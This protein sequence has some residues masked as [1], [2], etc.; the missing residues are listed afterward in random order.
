MVHQPQVALLT[1]LLGCAEEPPPPPEPA[2]MQWRRAGHLSAAPATGSFPFPG[3]RALLATCTHTPCVAERWEATDGTT[4]D[5]LRDGDQVR[6][7]GTPETHQTGRWNR[8]NGALAVCIGDPWSSTPGGDLAAVRTLVAHD[9]PSSDKTA[10]WVIR[11]S[12]ENPC[13]LSGDLELSTAADR[14]WSRGLSCEGTAWA[15]GGPKRARAL[16][17][18]SAPRG[19]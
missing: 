8:L 19:E 1:L 6:W 4:R 14:V 18:V 13:R 11:F 3:A 12:G 5:L 15:G 2:P 17:G 16:L 10:R 9:P 7:A